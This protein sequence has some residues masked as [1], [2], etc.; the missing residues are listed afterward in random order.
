LISQ[1]E[2]EIVYTL[3]FVPFFSRCFFL[4][5]KENRK[6]FPD[7]L[8]HDL[9]G[10]LMWKNCRLNMMLGRRF[11]EIADGIDYDSLE[12]EV[13]RE[14]AISRIDDLEIAISKGDKLFKKE[15]PRFM[16]VLNKYIE[17][18]GL[19]GENGFKKLKPFIPVILNDIGRYKIENFITRY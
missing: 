6:Y 1:T 11:H 19:L 13:L 7:L 12:Y 18:V 2:R 4:L 15:S 14:E 9:K 5:K 10:E 16:A 17:V 8:L 3:A